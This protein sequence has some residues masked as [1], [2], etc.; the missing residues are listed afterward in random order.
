MTTNSLRVPLLK[1]AAAAEGGGSRWGTLY[2]TGAVAALGL[3]AFT[4]CQMVVFIVWPPPSFLPTAAAVGDWFSM[5]QANRLIGLL[6][7]DLV[8]L[9]DYPASLLVFLAL[10]V[11]L[12]RSHQSVATIAA[13]LGL[14]GIVSYFAANPAF[15]MLSLSEQYAAAATDAQRT[16]LLAAGQTTLAIFAGSAF[17][18]SY[19]LIAI[20]GLILTL[21]MV[22]GSTFGKPTA[23]IGVAF[24][25]LTL[26][27]ASAGTLG[28][29]FSLASLVPMVVF[30]ILVARR[31]FQLAG[32]EEG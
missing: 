28:L 21:A 10:C 23:W 18:I 5:L 30:L 25:A 12:R 31:L 32:L 19:E 2:R 1:E 15:A 22:R 4:F 14:T 9:V 29:V 16:M 6:N 8:M 20:S 3:V 17:N 24:Y 13:A 11:A 26:V 7:L 27:P